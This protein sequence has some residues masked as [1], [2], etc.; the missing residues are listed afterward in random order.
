M[1]VGL[2][3]TIHSLALSHCYPTRTLWVALFPASPGSSLFKQPWYNMFPRCTN[4]DAKLNADTNSTWNHGQQWPQPQTILN[5]RPPSCLDYRT[6]HGSQP[7][8][9]DK[10]EI[11]IVQ[12]HKL[13]VLER[14]SWSFLVLSTFFS[15]VQ[16]IQDNAWFEIATVT[17]QRN[18]LNKQWYLCTNKMLDNGLSLVAQEHS[19]IT[20]IWKCLFWGW[21][22]K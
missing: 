9:S 6:R 4:I 13:Q 5:L 3:H 19:K 12:W 15:G 16:N 21:P 8:E 10:F 11:V 18:S 17:T 20:N 14:L 2:L 7:K 22:L 1:L